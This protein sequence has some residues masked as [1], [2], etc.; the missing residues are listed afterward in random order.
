[1]CPESSFYRWPLILLVLSCT[2]CHGQSA[3]GRPRAQSSGVYGF[4]GAGAPYDAP[5]G[6]LGE[7]IWIFDAN[8]RVQVAKAVCDE[9]APGEFRVPLAPGRYVVHGP[10]GK[11]PIE[12]KD[13]VWVKLKSVA[14][15]PIMP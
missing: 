9:R 12:V 13:G 15:L 11:R 4:S 3:T 6:V 14:S 8:D 10:G 1:M 2:A 5:E 7:C